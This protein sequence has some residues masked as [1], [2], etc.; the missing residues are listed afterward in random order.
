MANGILKYPSG[1]TILYDVTLYVGPKGTAEEA[2]LL[3]QTEILS[4]GE[5]VMRSDWEPPV[6]RK[7]AA[8]GNGITIGGKIPL[9]QIIPGSY[10]LRV[11]VR[12]TKTRKETQ[13]SALFEIEP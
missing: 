11:T 12:E 13:E 10:E 1:T 7:A 5:T 4:N 8:D 9:G 3:V 2:S 6:N